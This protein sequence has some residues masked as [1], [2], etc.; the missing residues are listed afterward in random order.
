MNP[1][2]WSA[3]EAIGT[4]G[5]T[6]VA[7]FF[8]YRVISEERRNRSDVILALFKEGDVWYGEFSNKGLN[9]AINV[10]IRFVSIKTQKE[11]KLERVQ[12]TRHQSIGNIQHGA[13]Q[14]INLFTIQLVQPPH[15]ATLGS[16]PHLPLDKEI[17]YQVLI[18]GD[19]F[20]AKLYTIIYDSNT[21]QF[22]VK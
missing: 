16:K 20:P 12:K 3:L 19:N 4:I 14:I 9:T 15:I 8:G 7:L 17:I 2:F 6:V 11:E 18:T 10:H 5:A 13:Y 21:Q 1:I 22:R